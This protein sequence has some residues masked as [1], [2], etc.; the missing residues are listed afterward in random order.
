MWKSRMLPPARELLPNRRI[1]QKR[2]QLSVTAVN[3]SSAN[4][5]RGHWSENDEKR[6]C[7]ETETDGNE[8]IRIAMFGLSAT[9]IAV[10]QKT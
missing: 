8:K 2:S 7:R 10:C 9:L 4:A 5:N 1:Q 6:V 3:L